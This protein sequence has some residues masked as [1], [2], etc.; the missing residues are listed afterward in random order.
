MLDK[1]SKIQCELNAP[2][3]LRNNFGNYNYRSCESIL[4][5]LKPVLEKNK[6]AATLT[7]ELVLVGD[8][9]YVKATAAVHDCESDKSVSVVA[10]AREELAKKGMDGSQIT[11]AAS[12]YAR[13]YALGGLFL[14]DDSR[15]SDS[16]NDH[17]K[18]ESKYK[19]P[20]SLKSG[21]ETSVSV[22]GARVNPGTGKREVNTK[23]MGI[24]LV[25]KEVEYLMLKGRVNK[26]ATNI[27]MTVNSDM[28]SVITEV[29]A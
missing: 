10:Y 28:E 21:K 26:G 8:R 22:T 23:E 6:C 12:S 13:K 27:R 9:I 15:D 25:E 24:M 2:K 3:S 16:T 14:I 20:V 19:E 18:S 7:D 29:V 17:G 5:A 11:G 1:L 4:E